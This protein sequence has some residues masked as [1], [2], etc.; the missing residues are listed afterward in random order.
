MCIFLNDNNLVT[1]KAYQNDCNINFILHYL[2]VY[3]TAQRQH[4]TCLSLLCFESGLLT[5]LLFTSSHAKSARVKAK[6]DS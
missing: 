6:V 4:H 5:A 3:D 1:G 2:I